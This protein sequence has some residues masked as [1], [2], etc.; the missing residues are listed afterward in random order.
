MRS[1]RSNKTYDAL[2]VTDDAEREAAA[3]RRGWGAGARGRGGARYHRS[4]P[5][6]PRR[7]ALGPR[8]RRPLPRRNDTMIA[9]IINNSCHIRIYYPYTYID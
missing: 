9:T 1:A 6:A 5:E 3:A 2:S 7:V 8:H 4:T